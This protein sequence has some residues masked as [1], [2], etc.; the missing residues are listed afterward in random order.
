MINNQSKEILSLQILD[1]SGHSVFNK[2]ISNSAESMD[3]S[4]LSNGVYFV[5]VTMG[6][7]TLNQ[8]IIKQ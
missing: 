4:W 6:S 5:K 7:A 2:K 3:L 8:K 1:L